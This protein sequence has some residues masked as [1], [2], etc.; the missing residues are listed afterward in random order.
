MATIGML[1]RFGPQPW[2][3]PARQ[4]AYLKAWAAP[5]ALTGM[6]NWYRA[7]PLLV[8]KVGE[9]IDP[10]AVPK[11][12]PASWRVRMAHLV[13]WGMDDKALLPVSRAALADYCD[14]LA[15]REIAGADHWLVHQRTAEVTGLIEAFLRD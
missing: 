10:C 4:A 12:E 5:G 9:E 15:V 7:T 1:R 8:P 3:T 11:L 2:L 6:L 14:N 13:I